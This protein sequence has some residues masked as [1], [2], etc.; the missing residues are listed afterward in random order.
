MPPPM[1]IG[2]AVVSAIVASLTSSQLGFVGGTESLS[3]YTY[4]VAQSV[5]EMVSASLSSRSSDYN[6]AYS[7]YWAV[8][9]Y[10]SC[11]KEYVYSYYFDTYGCYHSSNVCDC[12]VRELVMESASLPVLLGIGAAWFAAFM[13][14]LALLNRPGAL[15]LASCSIWFAYMRSFCGRRL[16]DVAQDIGDAWRAVLFMFTELMLIFAR[17]T[18]LLGKVARRL[19]LRWRPY[20]TT[21]ITAGEPIW[22]VSPSSSRTP[23]HRRSLAQIQIDYHV[24]AGGVRRVYKRKV[25]LPASRASSLRLTQPAWRRWKTSFNPSSSNTRGDCLFLVLAKY[26]K[27]RWPPTKLRSA[28]KMHAA[29]L[30][31]HGAPVLLGKSLADHLVEHNIEPQWFLSK[32]DSERPRWGNTIDVLVAA[33]LFSINFVVYDLAKRRAICRTRQ[34][35]PARYIGYS[36]CHFVAGCIRHRAKQVSVLPVRES[37]LAFARLLLGVAAVLCLVYSFQVLGAACWSTLLV[38]AFTSQVCTPSSCSWNLQDFVGLDLVHDS[39]VFIPSSSTWSQHYFQHSALLDFANAST[40]SLVHGGVRGLAAGTGDELLDLDENEL[41]RPFTVIGEGENGQCDYA[42]SNGH[43]LAI[44]LADHRVP[45]APR[46]VCSLVGGPVHVSSASSSCSWPSIGSTFEDSESDGDDTPRAIR[47]LH[48]RGML[49]WLASTPVSHDLCEDSP[50]YHSWGNPFFVAALDDDLHHGRL[51]PSDDGPSA[52]EV[53]PG[54]FADVALYLPQQD[55][56]LDEY[57][58]GYTD[59]ESEQRDAA[60][61]RRIC[62]LSGQL[63]TVAHG[64]P[65]VPDSAL[66]GEGLDGSNCELLNPMELDQLVGLEMTFAA[67]TPPVR[68]ERDVLEGLPSDDYWEAANSLDFLRFLLIAYRPQLLNWPRNVRTPLTL[69]D[70]VPT[71]VPGEDME[72]FVHA[73][74]NPHHALD[75]EHTFVVRWMQERDRLRALRAAQVVPR[76]PPPHP[77][78]VADSEIAQDEQL[79]ALRSA[80]RAHAGPA[81]AIAERHEA[82][83][84]GDLLFADGGG[85]A[86]QSSPCHSS[87]TQ[88]DSARRPYPFG[89]HAEVS[90]N[91]QQQVPSE[92]SAAPRQDDV[93]AAILV[94]HG[95]YAP[96]HL[97]HRECLL[98]ALRF[99]ALK[100]VYIE[101]AIVGFTTAKYVQDKTSDGDFSDVQLRFRIATEVL[102]SDVDSVHPITIDPAAYTSAY[103]CAQKHLVLGSKVIYL[104]GSDLSVRPPRETMVVTRTSADLCS[105]FKEFFNHDKLSGLCLQKSVLNVTSTKV[106]AVLS[107]RRMPRFYS[108]AARAMIQKALGWTCPKKAPCLTPAPEQNA[109][110]LAVDPSASASSVT[111]VPPSAVLVPAASV[112]QSGTSHKAPL[113]R[114]KRTA[115]IVFDTTA[116][117]VPLECDARPPL[118]RRFP[119][120]GPAH[121]SGPTPADIHVPAPPQAFML[122]SPGIMKL[123]PPLLSSIRYYWAM[124]VVPLC[125]MLEV[126]PFLLSRRGKEYGMRV[127]YVPQ[128]GPAPPEVIFAAPPDIDELARNLYQVADRLVFCACLSYV[129][130]GVAVPD[131]D[132]DTVRGRS[133]RTAFCDIIQHCAKRTMLCSIR[134]AFVLLHDAQLIMFVK[135]LYIAS[136]S[137]LADDV[138]E[139]LRGPL[140]AW[141]TG[142]G[143]ISANISIAV[144]AER[145]VYITGGAKASTTSSCDHMHVVLGTEGRSIASSLGRTSDRPL[146]MRTRSVFLCV[147]GVQR[148]IFVPAL[149]T[150]NDV[151]NE[152]ARLLGCS[153][154][155]V[156]MR[157]ADLAITVTSGVGRP[158]IFCSVLDQLRAFVHQLLADG[159]VACFPSTVHVS[160]LVV[161]AIRALNQLLRDFLPTTCWH[162]LTIVRHHNYVW[163]KDCSLCPGAYLIAF[164][165]SAVSMHLCSM[166]K[167]LPSFFEVQNRLVAFNPNLPFRLVCEGGRAVTSLLLTSTQ[168]WPEHIT[169]GFLQD[170]GFPA[171]L[172]TPCV[173][174]PLIAGG[175]RAGVSD[176]YGN[177]EFLADFRKERDLAM[178][179]VLAVSSLTCADPLFDCL[180]GFLSALIPHIP[181]ARLCQHVRALVSLWLG[182]A[183]KQGYLVAGLMVVDIADRFGVEF[184][185][186][187][188]FISSAM[189]PTDGAIYFVYAVGCLL[190]MSIS[191]LNSDNQPADGYVRPLGGVGLIFFRQRWVAIQLPA[192]SLKSHL[193]PCLLSSTQEFVDDDGG[194][195]S[196]QDDS[197]FGALPLQVGS[198]SGTDTVFVSGGAQF[199]VYGG[200]KRHMSEKR[201]HPGGES[202]APVPKKMVRHTS[203][204]SQ[205]PAAEHGPQP[206]DVLFPHWEP[207]DIADGAT[208][209]VHISIGSDAPF[210]IA[211]PSTWSQDFI[212]YVLLQHL[213]A[214]PEWI[215]RCLAGQDLSLDYSACFPHPTSDAISDAVQLLCSICDKDDLF[216]SPQQHVEVVLGV[217][218]NGPDL[219]SQF[220]G[221]NMQF[222]RCVFPLL[223]HVFESDAFNSVSVLTFRGDIAVRDVIS[224]LGSHATILP[225]HPHSDDDTQ[226]HIRFRHLCHDHGEESRE[227]Y[228]TP[229]VFCDRPFYL[230]DGSSCELSAT[231]PASVA[232]LQLVSKDPVP[233]PM[234]SPVV[235][236]DP[237]ITDA[238]GQEQQPLLAPSAQFPVPGSPSAVIGSANTKVDCS[239]ANP[240]ARVVGA[241]SRCNVHSMEQ[242]SSSSAPPSASAFETAVVQRLDNIEMKQ[243]EILLLLRQQQYDRSVVSTPPPIPVGLP[244]GARQVPPA[245]VGKSTPSKPKPQRKVSSKTAPWRQ[246]G[247]SFWKRSMLALRR[248]GTNAAVCPSWLVLRCGRAKPITVR[249]HTRISS[250]Q[251]I[252]TYA[253]EKRVGR[254]YIFLNVRTKR[255]SRQVAYSDAPVYAN[256]GSKTLSIVNKR[257]SEVSRIPIKEKKRLEEVTDHLIDHCRLIDAQHEQVDVDSLPVRVQKCAENMLR[258]SASASGATGS[259]ASGIPASSA[260]DMGPPPLPAARPN[261][262]LRRRQVD[263]IAFQTPNLHID[264]RCGIDVPRSWTLGQALA[265]L[266]ELMH[267]EYCVIAGTANNLCIQLNVSVPAA[268]EFARGAGKSCRVQQDTVAKNALCFVTHDLRGAHT[269]KVSHTLLKSVLLHDRKCALATFQARSPHQRLRAVAAA[270]TRMGLDDKA[271]ELLAWVEQIPTVVQQEYAQVVQ[272]SPEQQRG[273]SS[274]WR[275]NM[276]VGQVS[277][278]ANESPNGPPQSE[279]LLVPASMLRDITARLAA[280][281]AWAHAFDSQLVRDEGEESRA[282]FR[283]S[284][285]LAAL[286]S[287]AV[288]DAQQ[289]AVA[290]CRTRLDSLEARTP[291]GQSNQA[292]LD[293]LCQRQSKLERDLESYQARV[294]AEAERADPELGP[295]PMAAAA[296]SYVSEEKFLRLVRAVAGNTQKLVRAESM[297]SALRTQIGNDLPGQP[298]LPSQRVDPQADGIT[299]QHIMKL[300]SMHTN[301]ISQTWSWVSANVRVTQQHA[302]WLSKAA[303]SPTAPGPGPAHPPSASASRA[304][305][306]VS[307]VRADQHASPEEPVRRS[308]VPPLP[309]IPEDEED[310]RPLAPRADGS[311]VNADLHSP[312]PQIEEEVQAEQRS[313]PVSHAATEPESG[314][315]VVLLS[316]D[317]EAE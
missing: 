177:P 129:V 12:N 251:I 112:A 41:V 267:A 264:L 186:C 194:I 33:D 206:L 280:V 248:L 302:A 53:W 13:V 224:Q 269:I 29:S 56:T 38:Q 5:F 73:W 293:Y 101:R 188:G 227:G 96:M 170:L 312:Q 245:G 105:G 110:Q 281:E 218:L 184:H 232:V 23:V 246:G 98:T 209:L 77:G 52:R 4:E 260:M 62:L 36:K 156:L 21:A 273:P 241:P 203:S 277:Q 72:E 201:A 97:G 208:Q 117:D 51:V 307:A 316:S 151:E 271:E 10:G 154:D 26:L 54:R 247:A 163:H 147:N 290:D 69:D 189:T 95:S 132:P 213:A 317:S 236:V 43:D 121:A 225:L 200:V 198:E 257:Y 134:A 60:R 31:V 274:D 144:S 78:P 138:L 234:V 217:D 268:T 237:A 143:A 49:H 283:A 119:S 182:Q 294:A 40:L 216:E 221:M 63:A 284:E 91:L 166:I 90:S 107:Q 272:S 1:V 291:L 249:Y 58:L 106:R 169:Q 65:V 3:P 74:D 297:L 85:K 25:L 142:S 310:V 193:G 8:E 122:S 181:V 125:S 6:E 88:G 279:Q 313:D 265:R 173:Y 276:M 9:N 155:W 261:P 314:V 59:N 315:G 92:T 270:L 103:A 18:P 71:H 311:A 300:L 87:T 22:I 158:Q 230:H 19:A 301:A 165:P 46:S 130:G 145:T 82:D 157:W 168:S 44:F 266:R 226:V 304:D 55:D 2:F 210:D 34:S 141:Q 308:T 285:L 288:R 61:D 120:A 68:T 295:A 244:I 89:P 220:T 180:S 259:A 99:L 118:K 20:T 179:P 212:E 14:V 37:L 111:P 126:Q 250:K 24:T 252:E 113:P 45:V 116:N 306:C 178:A 231:G 146:R 162:T 207:M 140:A 94:Y 185:D 228:S 109:E 86:V 161:G 104:V 196:S 303:L 289:S 299:Q 159:T 309:A 75:L 152:V 229:W 238:S 28:L 42:I 172:A 254:Q 262:P 32:L 242:A 202:V 282:V 64:L 176:S 47:L 115:A 84:I 148:R 139:L 240:S 235:A 255:G 114:R 190:R 153:T 222:V 83:F 70:L 174:M 233:V 298:S 286:A 11:A 100:N 80:L 223:T 191:V 239:R 275:Q 258:T 137:V 192:Y 256:W 197:A 76:D 278:P 128:R 124:T 175:M 253:S 57:V 305:A 79:P 164:T 17:R 135:P 167:G 50:S 211:F 27:G 160:K 30:L 205:V 15:L 171:N 243:T 204:S 48:L 108:P 67:P 81:P 195:P 149:W 93:I 219:L 214:K 102:S 133:V 215:E 123:Q 287:Q 35:G 131:C 7:S 39:Q 183:A 296:S 292:D 136:A 199:F 263:R 187:P 16:H 66:A 150:M 127:S